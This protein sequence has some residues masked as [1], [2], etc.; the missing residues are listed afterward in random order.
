M[1]ILPNWPPPIIPTADTK[2]WE[3][4][5]IDTEYKNTIKAFDKRFSVEEKKLIKAKSNDDKGREKL[6]QYKPKL[7]EYQEALEV[8]KENLAA[9]KAAK[10]MYKS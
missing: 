10:D 5:A 9:F 7:K 8:A 4:K 2:P 3:I 6:K 1:T